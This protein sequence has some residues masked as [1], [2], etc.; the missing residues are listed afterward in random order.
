MGGSSK[1]AP[2][3]PGKTKLD[4]PGKQSPEFKLQ[5]TAGE[6]QFHKFQLSKFAIAGALGP[7]HV[8]VDRLRFPFAGATLNAAGSAK[9]QGKAT[10]VTLS[11][12]L[13]GANITDFLKTFGI[14]TKE[15][16]GKGRCPRQPGRRRH[17]IG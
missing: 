13:L 16:A 7:G 8:S 3:D 4:M 6:L 14:E 10:A 2:S 5:L 11:A 1:D 15:I 12:D 17:Y 9:Q